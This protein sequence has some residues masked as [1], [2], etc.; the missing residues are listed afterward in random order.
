MGNIFSNPGLA[1]G[2]LPPVNENDNGKILKVVEGMWDKATPSGGS[3]LPAVTADDNGSVLTVVEGEWDKAPTSSDV[4][5]VSFTA[6]ETFSTATSNKTVGEIIDAV[7]AGKFV[8][9]VCLY[10][11]E[12]EQHSYPWIFASYSSNSITFK[13]LT[14]AGT[15]V[16]NYS[17]LDDYVVFDLGG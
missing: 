16:A 1:Q 8:I 11:W 5:A 6:D 13:D 15:Y 10:F 3:S 4:L 14:Y 9:G 17:T 2:T 12:S 7:D